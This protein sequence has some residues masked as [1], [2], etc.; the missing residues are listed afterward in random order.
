[1]SDMLLKSL[2]SIGHFSEEELETIM[3]KFKTMSHEAGEVLLEIG[4]TCDRFWFL[5]QGSIRQYHK[6]D[7]VDEVN[8]GLFTAGSWFLDHT[9]FTGR[10]PARYRIEAYGASKISSI[11]V[12]HL[13]DLMGTSQVYFQLG[14]I[15]EKSQYMAFDPN[16]KPEQRYL[17]VL[18]NHPALL[19][20]FP[21][22]HIASY[23]GMTPETLSRVRKRISSLS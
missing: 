23:L 10:K 9:S 12:H 21:L 19:T 7:N 8:H 4:E 1:M 20:A 11:S 18:E 14:K 17:E 6:N 2:R 13:H 16:S 22:K 3:G 5:E 15:L